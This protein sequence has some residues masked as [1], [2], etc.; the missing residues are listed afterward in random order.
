MLCMSRYIVDRCAEMR[1]LEKCYAFKPVKSDWDGTG[2]HANYPT[3]AMRQ[4]GGY[5]NVII[6]AIAKFSSNHAKHID[7]YGTDN[8]ERLTGKH[9]TAII[10]TFR[11]M[12]PAVAPPFD[13]PT[14]WPNADKVTSKTAPG[15]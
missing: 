3:K 6:P 8:E 13:S 10:D 14:M 1:G 7:L 9:E 11:W 4:P 12:W 15:W 2:C 5:E